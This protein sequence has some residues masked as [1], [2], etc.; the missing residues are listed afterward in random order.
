VEEMKQLLGR[1]RPNPFSEKELFYYLKKEHGQTLTKIMKELGIGPQRMKRILN[2]LC[3]ENKLE[4]VV[5][6]ENV[7]YKVRDV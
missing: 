4:K 7:Y 1:G 3:K 2:Q 5:F 6:G